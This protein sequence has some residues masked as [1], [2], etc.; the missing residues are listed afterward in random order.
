MLNVIKLQNS[1]T[2]IKLWLNRSSPPEILVAE[3]V[4]DK[5]VPTDSAT[6]PNIT[7]ALS[8]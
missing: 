2:L 1:N 4:G 7:Y 5:E 8:C 6:T 3:S